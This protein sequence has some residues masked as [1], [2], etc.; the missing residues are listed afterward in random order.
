MSDD[1]TSWHSS[2]SSLS[3]DDEIMPENVIRPY[4]FKPEFSSSDE[5][6]LEGEFDREQHDNENDRTRN[7]HW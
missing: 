4:Q 7:L 5:G 3:T 1:K 6:V 2:Q